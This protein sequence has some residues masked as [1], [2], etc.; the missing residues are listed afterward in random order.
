[1]ETKKPN[2][3]KKQK[4]LLGFAMLLFILAIIINLF[5]KELALLEIVFVFVGAVIAFL[6]MGNKKNFQA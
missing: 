6:I 4:F 2:I 3:S 1:M 5:F